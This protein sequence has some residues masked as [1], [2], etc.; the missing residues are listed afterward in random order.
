[1]NKNQ[2]EVKY[3]K[4]KIKTRN[5]HCGFLCGERGSI[6]YHIIEFPK[7]PKAHI[8]WGL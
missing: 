5:V 2:A 7:M 4:F 8:S 6:T 3:R 1:M